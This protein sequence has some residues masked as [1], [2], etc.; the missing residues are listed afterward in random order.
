V[1]IIRAAKVVIFDANGQVLLLRRSETHPNKALQLDLPGGIVEDNETFEEGVQREVQE[2]TGL[3]IDAKA[4]NLV[5]TLTHDYFGKPVSRLLYSTHVN[6]VAPEIDISN[7]H[8]EYHWVNM[9]ELKGIEQPFQEG[10]DY[11]NRHDLW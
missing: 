11:A 4:L 7:E 6:S 8:S 3:K 1:P 9:S 2:E 10:I 5:Y